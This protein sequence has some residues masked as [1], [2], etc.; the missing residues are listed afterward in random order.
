[1]YVSEIIA[2]TPGEKND[3]PGWAATTVFKHVPRHGAIAEILPDEYRELI[4]Y[5]FDPAAFH[6]EAAEFRSE[7]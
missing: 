5:G 2:I 6:A 1:R 3:G 4:H 7:R